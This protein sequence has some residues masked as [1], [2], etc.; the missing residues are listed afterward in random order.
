MLTKCR[1]W[2]KSTKSLQVEQ[3]ANLYEIPSFEGR[4][5]AEWPLFL[6]DQFKEFSFIQSANIETLRFCELGT[7]FVA[8]HNEVGF[9]GYGTG[10][11]AA[12][13]LNNQLRIIPRHLCE[14]SGK[15]ENLPR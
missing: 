6:G 3:A 15:H 13:F 2:E 7:G 12:E 9:L 4:N 11:L 10:H 14:R 1:T 5:E 8:V